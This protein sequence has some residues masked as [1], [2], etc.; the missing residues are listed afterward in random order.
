MALNFTGRAPPEP[1]APGPTR[2]SFVALAIFGIAAILACVVFLGALRQHKADSPPAL[3]PL[4]GFDTPASPRGPP[5]PKPAATASVASEPAWIMHKAVVQPP[6]AP[7]PSPPSA[8]APAPSAADKAKA[9]AAAKVR[10]LAALRQVPHGVITL[11]VED[12]PVAQAYA[13]KL[14]SLFEEAG[15]RV[16]ET[17]VFGSGPPRRGLA[18]AFGVSPEGEAVREA[19]DTIG[20]QF[21]PPPRD[22]ISRTPE[23]F[24]GVP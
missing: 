10:M 11:A 19:F 22:S 13:K 1:E 7:A 12:D 15:W 17:S 23:I 5:P 4:V 2:G 6:P 16:E 8:N 21:Q 9:E 3:P 18:A 24:V 14:A 20:F